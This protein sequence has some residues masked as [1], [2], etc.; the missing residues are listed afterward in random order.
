M[1]DVELLELAQSALLNAALWS[2]PLLIVGVLVG[3]VVG[4][5]QAVTQVHDQVL[6]F[7][8]KLLV[9]LAVFSLLLPWLMQQLSQYA[10]TL[11]TAV[12]Y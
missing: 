1:S 10:S 12:P 9:V 2:A 6:S 7:A 8:P 4:M 11:F 3:V 5:I